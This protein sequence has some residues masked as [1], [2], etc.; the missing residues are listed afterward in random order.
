MHTYTHAHTHTHTPS[1]ENNR[2]HVFADLHWTHSLSYCL[3]LPYRLTAITQ[4]NPLCFFPELLKHKTQVHSLMDAF[5][6]KHIL[7]S[8][9]GALRSCVVDLLLTNPAAHES[10]EA[11]SVYVVEINPLAEYAGTGLFTWTCAVDKAL[12][13]GIDDLHDY[14]A[15][16]AFRIL[17]RV[18]PDQRL[19]VRQMQANWRQFAELTQ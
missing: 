10:Y 16:S 19:A 2:T 1:H 8:L 15:A 7:P 17:E 9:S 4:Y 14:E 5:V 3:V 11:L 18:P 13:L 6:R 12:L